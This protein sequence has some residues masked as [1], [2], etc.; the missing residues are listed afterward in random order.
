MDQHS[1]RVVSFIALVRCI[2]RCEGFVSHRRAGSKKRRGMGLGAEE[3]TAN[4]AYTALEPQTDVGR[5][6]QKKWKAK[7]TLEDRQFAVHALDYAEA[8]CRMTMGARRAYATSKY[9]TSQEKYV[10]KLRDALREN[11]L[12]QKNY[13]ILA[14]IVPRYADWLDG[15]N[16]EKA[17]RVSTPLGKV[18]SQ[19]MVQATVKKATWTG[20]DDNLPLHKEDKAFC[21]LKFV[22]SD[23]SVVSVQY[24]GI[25]DFARGEGYVVR[26]TVSNHTSY[27]TVSETD[28]TDIACSCVPLNVI[29]PPPLTPDEMT[30]LKKKVQ[31]TTEFHNEVIRDIWRSDRCLYI[32][33]TAQ[34]AA[35][36]L[37]MWL[38]VQGPVGR[39]VVKKMR[40][41]WDIEAMGPFPSGM[42]LPKTTVY[43]NVTQFPT[44]NVR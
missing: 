32:P 21:L 8:S 2:S 6:V 35:A 41:A 33:K 13:S 24:R 7:L 16:N 4:V 29:C 37:V 20:R 39:A 22:A 34:R 17:G 27:R 30:L 36:Q 9:K 25:T 15:E 5:A 1:G 23:G 40:T 42:D 14:T 12:H 19:V 43:G 10:E 28:L 11:R 31:N 38:K 3:A 44:F 18:N 26:G